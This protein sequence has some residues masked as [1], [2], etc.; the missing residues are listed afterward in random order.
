MD[1]LMM[2]LL[3]AAALCFFLA[4]INIS[5]PINL[6]AMGLLMWVMVPLITAA[7]AMGK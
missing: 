3:I 1:M 6:M 7:Q 2:F 5:A 4:T